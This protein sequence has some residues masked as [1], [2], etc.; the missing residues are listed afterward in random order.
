MNKSQ[1]KGI[2]AEVGYTKLYVPHLDNEL[3]FIHPAKGPNTYLNVNSQILESN[4][5]TP[6]MSENASLIYSAWQNPKDKYSSEII[7]KLRSNWLWSFNGI[8][9]VQ[10]E[11]AYIQDSPEVKEGKVSINKSDL[12]KK[13]ESKDSTARFVPFGYKIGKQTP[14]ELEKN[15]FVQALAGEE[16]AEKLAEVASKYKANP[17]VWSF[18]NVDENII[19]IASL[20][21]G[22]LLGSD[23]LGVGGD[24]WDGGD[25]GCA[26]G[27]SEAS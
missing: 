5:K 7:E 9:Y 27:V 13:L 19:R 25:D 22:R 20:L 12:V 15:P 18:E 26:F 24:D 6:T 4:L 3:T 11:G 1:S 16:G 2:R 23:R 14:K 8:L 10:N 21:S 17:Y